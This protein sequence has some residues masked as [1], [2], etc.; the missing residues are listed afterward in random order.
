MN[1]ISLSNIVF[2]EHTILKNFPF[3][4]DNIVVQVKKNGTGGV[5]EQEVICTKTLIMD[6]AEVHG[7]DNGK[8]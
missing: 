4:P 7:N 3:Y 1:K 8:H 2:V 6:K 5:I